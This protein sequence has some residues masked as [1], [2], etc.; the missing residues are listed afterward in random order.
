MPDLPLTS[1]DSVLR[2]TPSPFAAAVTVKPSASMHSC[3]TIR[4]GCGGVFIDIFRP[5][6]G[7]RSNRPRRGQDLLFLR[8][9]DHINTMAARAATTHG[10]RRCTVEVAPS[11][12]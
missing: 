5:P 6:N 10:Q 12:V 8:F 4:P 7:S 9:E 1:S 11:E 2:V 3:R